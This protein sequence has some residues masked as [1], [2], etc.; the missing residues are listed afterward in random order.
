MGAAILALIVTIAGL[1]PWLGTT[2]PAEIDPTARNRRPG[3]ER[4]IRHEDG[5]RIVTTYHM[6]TDSLGRDVYSRVMYGSRV[7]LIVG[8][9]VAVVSAAVGLVIGLVSGYVRWLDGVVMRIM[10]GLMSIPAILLAIA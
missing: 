6:G 10:D 7:S 1:A 9:T 2:N 4:V 5:T 8:V 3:A